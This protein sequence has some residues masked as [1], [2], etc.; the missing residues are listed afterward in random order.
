[1]QDNSKTLNTLR[2]SLFMQ[3]TYTEG[4][5]Y[6]KP[7]ILLLIR[8]PVGENREQRFAVKTAGVLGL[9]CIFLEHDAVISP[10]TNTS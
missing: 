1:M 9:E 5:I 7:F 4:R 3:A 2:C 6:V 10:D 8:A